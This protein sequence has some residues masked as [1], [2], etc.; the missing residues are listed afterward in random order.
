MH[1]AASL[2]TPLLADGIRV[3]FYAGVEDAM[4][5]Y[6]GI[7]A[8]VEELDNVFKAEYNAAP[9]SP[10]VLLGGK[11]EVGLVKVAGA[12]G[13]TAGNLAFVSVNAAGHMVPTDA[14]DVALDLFARWIHN[15]PLVLSKPANATAVAA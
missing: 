5:S 9:V 8:L 13:F 12:Q 10:Y 1:Y 4:C 2:L 3:L 14:P 11:K 15:T 7:R 6:T